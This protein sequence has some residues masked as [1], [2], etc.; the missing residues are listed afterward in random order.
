MARNGEV[1]QVKSLGL[2]L[3]LI[4]ISIFLA[5]HD[6]AVAAGRENLW[7]LFS[8]EAIPGSHD[9]LGED[10]YF[11]R[12]LREAGIQIYVDHALSWSVLHM[13]QKALSNA[14]TIAEKDAFL[15]RLKG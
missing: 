7:P 1:S 2:G 15:E 14:D 5:L 12:Q 6:H 9:V 10:A 4:D 13:H 3:C 8:F 11:F